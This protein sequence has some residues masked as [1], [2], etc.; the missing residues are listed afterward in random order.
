MQT[1]VKIA[2]G[3]AI[4]WFVEQVAADILRE[5]GA[6]PHTAKVAGAIAGALV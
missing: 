6:P 1:I 3:A 5:L 4:G 2:V